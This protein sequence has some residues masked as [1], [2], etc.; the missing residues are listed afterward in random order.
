MIM[1]DIVVEQIV[2]KQKT[3]KDSLMAFGLVAL[4][5]VLVAVLY[6]VVL[7]FV[8]QFSGIVFMLI[9][10]IVYYT[11]MIAGTFNLE[12]EYALV[13]YD[14]DI[15][16]IIAKKNRKKITY[17]DL[18]SVEA[19]GSKEAPEFDRYLNDESIIKVYACRLKDAEDTRFLI[20]TENLQK[21][22]VLFSPSEEL[23]ENIE[24]LCAR[25][26]ER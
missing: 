24:K 4:C 16:K 15:D 1:N 10:L 22:M 20:Y 23:S 13:N 25:R 7:P 9:A 11:Y 26:L 19:F 3:A 21:K 18:K 17:V 2:K 12:Y 6:M 14:L 5:V 8:P